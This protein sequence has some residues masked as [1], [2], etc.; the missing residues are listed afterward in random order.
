MV[1]LENMVNLQDSIYQYNTYLADTF[2]YYV[3]ISISTVNLYKLGKA[4]SC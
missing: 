3:I 1:N 2:K 4:E